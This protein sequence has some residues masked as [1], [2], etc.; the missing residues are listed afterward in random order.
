VQLG[1]I[2]SDGLCYNEA[3]GHFT[4]AVDASAAFRNSAIH[5]MYKELV[6]VRG[7]TTQIPFTL[8]CTFFSFAAI[9]VGP[10]DVVASCQ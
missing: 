2:S 7:D 9:R 1:T 5:L 10:R 6:V 3:A 8:N 4:V